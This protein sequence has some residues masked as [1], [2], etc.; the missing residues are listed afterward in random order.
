M[1]DAFKPTGIVNFVLEGVLGDLQESAGRHL[2]AIAPGITLTLSATKPKK[3]DPEATIEQV[4]KLV[5]VQV[6]GAVELRPR[7]VKQLSGGERRRV[8]VALA[9]GFTE[10][11]ARRCRLRRSVPA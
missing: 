1:D 6:P 7:A 8:A 4:E 11:A 3:S 5:F 10:L 2:A 9:L